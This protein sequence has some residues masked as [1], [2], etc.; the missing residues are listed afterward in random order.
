VPQDDDHPQAT[1][2]YTSKK[3][4]K[5]QKK[6]REQKE[7]Q[8]IRELWEKS[9]LTRSKAAQGGNAVTVVDQ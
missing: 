5:K 8:E 3:E 6:M 2:G 7:L 4:T 9:K 1:A